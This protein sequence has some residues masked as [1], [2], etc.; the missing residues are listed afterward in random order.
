M[1]KETPSVPIISRAD[2]K[3]LDALEK[4]LQK[5]LSNSQYS[6]NNLAYDLELSE[7]QLRRRIKQLIG[8]SP[9]QYLKEVR[10][11]QARELLENKKYNSVAKTAQAVG[12]Q[13]VRTFSRN[14]LTHFGKKPSE[15]LSS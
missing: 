13:D 9:A 4:I 2:Q 8:L 12:F 14:F 3:W 10:L 11:H 7:R 1:P 15:Y 5:E 6:I